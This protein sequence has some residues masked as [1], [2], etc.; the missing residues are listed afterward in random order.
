MGAYRDCFHPRP[1]PLTDRSLVLYAPGSSF[2]AVSP[3]QSSF[4]SAPARCLSA[5]SIPAEV[6]SL[7]AT[8][9]E[10]F[11]QREA[12]HTIATF[13]P[14]AFS[15]SRRLTP[16]SSFTGLFHPVATSRV[17]HR[18]GAS[19]SVQPRLPHRKTVPPCRCCPL[20]HSPKAIATIRHLDFEVLIRTKMRSSGSVV[21]LTSGRSPLRFSSSSRYSAFVVSAGS[22]APS[23]HEVDCVGLLTLARCDDRS[24]FAHS[25]WLT[26]P[27]PLQ[28][29]TNE[30]FRLIRLRTNRT[31]TRFP[32][33]LPSEPG[34]LGPLCAM[35]LATTC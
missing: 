34:W 31:C 7:I 15:A 2:L 6:P 28:R 21:N 19:P 8:S 25:S 17:L 35:W 3:V 11:T 20:A 30:R 4:V 33:F 27:I 5:L 23:A 26:A 12:F 32:A 10:T 13:R 29:L 9:P 1:G 22:P 14:Q 18:S 16:S 24:R